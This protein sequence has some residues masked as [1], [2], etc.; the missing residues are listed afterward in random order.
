MKA[1]SIVSLLIFLVI[2][3]IISC[4][5]NELEYS[6][7]FTINKFVR[8]NREELSHISINEMN[9]YSIYVQRAIFNSWDSGKKRDTWISKINYIIE[10][11]IL[12]EDELNH[13]QKL[14]EHI[15]EDYFTNNQIEDSMRN[16]S[17]FAEKWVIFAKKELGF[18]E[19]YIAF[20][21]YRLY[22]TQQQ[23]E[24]ELYT[25]NHI[26]RIPVTDGEYGDCDCNSSADFCGFLM[27]NSGNCNITSGCGWFWSMPYDGNCF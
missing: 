6:C 11:E 15:T 7:D 25:I 21:V 9:T 3:T 5:D 10:N 17:A 20:L 27:C 8:K 22:L 23:L 26:E 16:R 24:S 19:Q 18:S 1:K 4:T 14:L 13:I 12:N 2:V